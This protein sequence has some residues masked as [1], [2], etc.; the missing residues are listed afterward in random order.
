MNEKCLLNREVSDGV[1]DLV[2]MTKARPRT[3]DP[4]D[5][6]LNLQDQGETIHLGF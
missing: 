6:G 2:L 3:L 5:Q 4:Q 1:K